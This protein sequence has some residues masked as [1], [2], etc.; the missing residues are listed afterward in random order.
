MSRNGSLAVLHP[1]LKIEDTYLTIGV[2]DKIL[3][4][5]DQLEAQKRVLKKQLSLK[6]HL[7]LVCI[8]AFWMH[9]MVCSLTTFLT[10][11]LKIT[12]LPIFVLSGRSFD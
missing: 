2:N 6:R 12:L 8:R 3:R 10:S 4:D 1:S 11:K 5:K 7:G 9:I